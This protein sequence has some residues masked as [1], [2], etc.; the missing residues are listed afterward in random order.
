MPPEINLERLADDVL[1][2]LK[3]MGENFWRQISA[4]QVPIVEKAA[5]GIAKLALLAVA[6]PDKRGEHMA[7]IMHLRGT[8]ESEAA[9][10]A[11]R[12]NERIRA[13]IQRVIQK[14]LGA[15]LAIL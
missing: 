15:V 8:I 13:A 4:E 3:A 14:A 10:T 5:R 2:D 7:D 9:L 11:M 6:E 1:E 12:A